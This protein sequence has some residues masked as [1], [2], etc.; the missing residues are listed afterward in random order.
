MP[1]PSALWHVRRSHSI[2]REHPELRSFPRHDPLALLFIFGVFLAQSSLAIGAAM[3]P[4]W[5]AAIAGWSVGGVLGTWMFSNAHELVHK[6]VHPAI[7][8]W[9][10]EWLMR[11]STMPAF[12]LQNYAAFRWGHLAHHKFL[13]SQSVERATSLTDAGKIDFDIEASRLYYAVV[14]RAGEAPAFLFPWVRRS[15]FRR[16]AYVALC[17][18]GT[19]LRSLLVI[20]PLL[21]I[22]FVKAL[23]MSKKGIREQYFLSMGVSQ[24]VLWS[25]VAG[26]Y[27]I[28]QEWGSGENTLVYLLC[29]ELGLR[30]FFFHPAG[31]LYLGLHL[32]TDQMA[33]A[34]GGYRPTRSLVSPFASFFLLGVNLHT[35]HH[36]FPGMPR[37]YLHRLRKIAP[38]FFTPP[39]PQT[40]TYA[41]SDTAGIWDTYRRYLTADSWYYAGVCKALDG[42]QDHADGPVWHYAPEPSAPITDPVA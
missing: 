1:S 36:D 15:L 41:H 18:L 9:R 2:L 12:S 21:T 17:G 38:E 5:A 24:I 23:L 4:A 8:G 14:S 3:W 34:S 31:V 30:G 29:A 27:W 20:Q 37:R 28:G 25:L 16:V 35:E 11:L 7:V 6:L 22:Q 10:Y 26:L 19:M 32:T 33:D 42:N 40:P 13:G 39:P